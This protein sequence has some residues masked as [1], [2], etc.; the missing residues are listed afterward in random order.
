MVDSIKKKKKLTGKSG[1]SHTDCSALQQKVGEAKENPLKVFI[2]GRYL[3]SFPP[4]PPAPG[5]HPPRSLFYHKRNRLVFELDLDFRKS[6]LNWDWANYFATSGWMP[7][8]AI[9]EWETYLD[10]SCLRCYETTSCTQQ[11]PCSHPETIFFKEFSKLSSA[12]FRL[13]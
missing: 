6:Q 13:L 2:R 11:P 5:S 9:S 7:S 1:A 4:P 10:H 3:T 8:P 12:F